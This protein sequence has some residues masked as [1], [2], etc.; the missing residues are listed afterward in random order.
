MQ[1]DWQHIDTVLLDMDGTLLDLHF[2]SYFW[3]RHLPEVYAQKNNLSVDQATEFLKPIFI[4]NAR[5]LNWY[6]VP[7]WSEQVGFDILQHKEEVAHNIAYRPNAQAFLAACRQNSDDVRMIT[8][9]HRRVLDLKISHTQIDQYFDQMICSHEL[10]YPKE[11]LS[12]W[13]RLQKS[14]EFDPSRTL[15]IDDSEYVLDVAHEYGIGHIYSIAEP[16]SSR[17]RSEPSKFPMIETFAI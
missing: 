13:E 7:F 2:D 14:A 3:L 6:S 10:D 9:G 11:H 5:T 4:N 1:I 8:N 16:D 15:F 12:F 17:Q